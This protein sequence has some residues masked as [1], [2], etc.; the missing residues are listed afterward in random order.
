MRP[1]D[2]SDRLL[3]L[4]LHIQTSHAYAPPARNLSSTF[5]YVTEL[6][7]LHARVEHHAMQRRRNINTKKLELLRHV[8]VIDANT[9]NLLNDK[10]QQPPANFNALASTLGSDPF[11]PGRVKGACSDGELLDGLD[12]PTKAFLLLPAGTPR[13]SD[14]LIPDPLGR[15]TV[16]ANYF[17]SGGEKAAFIV[18]GIVETFLFIASILGFIGACAR[19]QSFVV[20]YASFLYVHFFI[21]LGVAIYFL[22]EVT[23][24]ANTDI[25]KLCQES[26]RNTQAEG[27]CSGLLNITKGV[28]WGISL[29]V[30]AIEA[31]CALVVTRYGNQLRYEKRDGRQSR[32][33][34]RQS[35]YDAFHSRLSGVV[36]EEAAIDAKYGGSNRYSAVSTLGGEDD[37]DHLLAR[38][39]PQMFNPYEAYDTHRSS[40][41]QTPTFTP[42]RDFAQS[43]E[44]HHVGDER[45]SSTDLS[46]AP[47][48]ALDSLL[49][50]LH[51]LSFLLSPSLL[52]LLC[53]CATQFQ[54]ARARELDGRRSLAFWF[55]LVALV[56]AGG[57][58]AHAVGPGSDNRAVVL[59]FVGMGYKPSK[60]QLLLLDA[61]IILFQALL[62]TISYETSLALA[63]PADVP[64]PLLPESTPIL[65]SPGIELENAPFLATPTFPSPHTAS[66]PTRFAY[67]PT[68]TQPSIQQRAPALPKVVP[69]PFN[70]AAAPPTRDARGR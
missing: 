64:D 59:D 20:V 50:Q 61:T 42:V 30:L 17:M 45:Q 34:Q 3:S 57:V 67:P 8:A 49:Y 40:R 43:A 38:S 58:W 63:M 36:Y 7:N 23:V 31:Y 33:L 62:T 13:C 24:A 55:A 69:P 65:S 11:D 54:F 21:N 27:Q 68:L 29:L 6:R 1:P 18:A 48:T 37:K 19:K 47:V 10:L 46:A 32:M 16:D 41:A 60:L 25:V 56:N 52:I 5:S 51:T 22:R 9:S 4:A 15:W 28:Y 2:I 70:T 66:A 44:V 53:R 26:I 12:I 14:S 39:E 35:A